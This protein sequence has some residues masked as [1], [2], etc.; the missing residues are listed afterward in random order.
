MGL[1]WC[2]LPNFSFA[3]WCAEECQNQ[4]GLR[5]GWIDRETFAVPCCFVRHRINLKHT[6]IR[7]VQNPGNTF[8]VLLDSLPTLQMS[9]Q[10]VC[11]VCFTNN[12]FDFSRFL[13]L[14]GD[15][16]FWMPLLIYKKKKAYLHWPNN[17]LQSSYRCASW[18]HPC[19]QPSMTLIL[20]SPCTTEQ[21]TTRP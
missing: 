17:D 1:S 8:C 10:R 6:I 14:L 5:A 18:L 13:H 21:A 9:K 3:P 11:L 16:K 7:L 4:D 12:L 15:S 2:M 20:S 19:Q